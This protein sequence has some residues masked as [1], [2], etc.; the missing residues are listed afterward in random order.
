[1]R[2]FELDQQ[3]FEA[4]YYDPSEDKVNTRLPTDTRKPVLT[5]KQVN[6]LKKI[7][8]VQKLENLKRH[9]LLKLIYG[10]PQGDAGGGSPF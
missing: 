3:D 6:R 4:A 1:M 10:Q 9:D 7:R 5:L 2:L 8:A